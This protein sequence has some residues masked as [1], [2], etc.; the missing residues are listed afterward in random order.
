MSR[1]GRTV[2]VSSIIAT[3]G[4]VLQ[5]MACVVSNWMRW[6]TINVSA[7]AAGTIGHCMARMVRD[8]IISCPHL[9][10]RSIRQKVILTTIGTYDTCAS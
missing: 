1:R 9:S 7:A 3:A 5:G 2:P 4:T 10:C 8:R 6:V